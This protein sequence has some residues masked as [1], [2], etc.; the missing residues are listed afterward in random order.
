M[1]ADWLTHA[2]C[3]TV[4]TVLFFDTIPGRKGAAAYADDARAACERCPMEVRQACLEEALATPYVEDHGLRAG[5]SPAQRQR[6][7]QG[8]RVAQPRRGGGNYNR[9][10]ACVGCGGEFLSPGGGSVRCDECLAKGAA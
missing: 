4:P 8:R 3:R 1:T 10:R 9:R 7:R 2:A 5:L 6:L